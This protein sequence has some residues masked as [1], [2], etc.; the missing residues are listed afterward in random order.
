MSIDCKDWT[1]IARDYMK[2]LPMPEIRSKKQPLR[3]TVRLAGFIARK[4]LPEYRD[5]L[6]EFLQE[7]TR[8]I[9]EQKL[10]SKKRVR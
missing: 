3:Y 5:S 6:F 8:N 9:W 10:R 4:C 7:P 2:L 1:G